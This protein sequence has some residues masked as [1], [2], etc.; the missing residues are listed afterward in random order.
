MVLA[1]VFPQLILLGREV[2]GGE[3]TSLVTNVGF[4]ERELQSGEAADKTSST[5]VSVPLVR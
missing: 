3:N 1:V 4:P 2:G 5:F